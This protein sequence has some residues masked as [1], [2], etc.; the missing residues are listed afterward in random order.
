MRP[1]LDRHAVRVDEVGEVVLR[2][3]HDVGR[4]ADAVVGRARV[5]LGDRRHEQRLR[6]GIELVVGGNEADERRVEG[7]EPLAQERGR[8]A[9]G[10]A[11]DEDDLHLRGLVGLH[12]LQGRVHVGHDRGAD[13]GAVGVANVDER[14]LVRGLLRQV[15][16]LAGGVGEDEIRPG[17]VGGNADAV[18]DGSAR[19]EGSAGG[20]GGRRSAVLRRPAAAGRDGDGGESEERGKDAETARE[21]HKESLETSGLV[22]AQGLGYSARE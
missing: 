21:T 9:V 7:V 20:R 14:E 18:I 17:D 10:V 15:V 22:G 16:G 1:V 19:G 12:L 2:E 8:V 3:H 5:F 13:V 4:V 6:D 11:G